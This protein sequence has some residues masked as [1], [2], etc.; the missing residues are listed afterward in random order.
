MSEDARP[1]RNTE[2]GT[3]H[4]CPHNRSLYVPTYVPILCDVIRGSGMEVDYCSLRAINS[5]PGQC[6]Y[7]CMLPMH[8]AG[9]LLSQLPLGT[10]SSAEPTPGT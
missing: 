10:R 2:G 9:C 4:L 1:E 7:G 3:F 6:H 5:A 8:P